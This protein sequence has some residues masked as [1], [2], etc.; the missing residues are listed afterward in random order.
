MRTYSTT[1][2]APGGSSDAVRSGTSRAGWTGPSCSTRLPVKCPN[3]CRGHGQCVASY[4]GGAGAGLPACVCDKG[5][6]G[7]DCS[8]PACPGNC[9]GHGGC[10]ADATCAC[11]AGWS[12]EMCELGT[13]PNDCDGHGA[14][15]P[16]GSCACYDGFS[17]VDCSV[18]ACVDDCGEAAG[19][20]MCLRGKCMCASA[21]FC[22]GQLRLLFTLMQRETEVQVRANIAVALGDLVVRHAN[23]LAPWTSHL[24]AQ[25]RD[26]DARV[27]K[28]I[29]M[30]LTHLILNEM[31][32]VKGQVA[33]MALCLLDDEPRIGALTRLFFTEF[34]KKSS[35]P[36]A[37][38]SMIKP[39]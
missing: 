34:A 10:A 15:Q 6:Q 16:D 18:H 23:L 24:Y 7:V 37:V 11:D 2:P 9:S 27:R 3:D 1:G 13:C 39:A 5:W 22:E 26:T 33:E 30:V 35:S 14:C 20:G 4:E 29:L 36:V 17:G 19:R 8:R 12:G 31:I 21:T 28:T 25:L 32:K 38:P